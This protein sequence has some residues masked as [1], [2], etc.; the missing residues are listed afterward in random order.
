VREPIARITLLCGQQMCQ[1]SMIVESARQRIAACRRLLPL[2]GR[3]QPF[4]DPSH[5]IFQNQ[6]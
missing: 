4:A 1:R 6:A 5:E 3:C 2:P